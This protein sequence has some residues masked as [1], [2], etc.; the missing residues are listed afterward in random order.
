M[1]YREPEER[2]SVQRCGDGRLIQQH[3]YKD[4]YQDTYLTLD[5]DSLEISYGDCDG[6]HAHFSLDLSDILELVRMRREG[7]QPAASDGGEG[8]Q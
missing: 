5:G 3:H 2:F 1:A 7:V 4:N 8:K 6:D